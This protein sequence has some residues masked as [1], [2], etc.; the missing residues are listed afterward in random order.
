LRAAFGID[1]CDPLSYCT[2]MSQDVSSARGMG[3]AAVITVML[4]SGSCNTLLMKFMVIQYVPT[5]PNGE[6]TG[7][8]HPYFQSLLMMIGEMLCLIAYWTSRTPAEDQVASG[9]VPVHIFAVACLFDWTATTL[10]NM[11][12]GVIAASVVQMT[13][14]AIVIFTCAF[15]VAFLGK[16][17]HAYHLLGVVLVFM[18]ITM[19][20]LS[21]FINPRHISESPLPHDG[22][23]AVNGSGKVFG[24]ALCV[25]AQV[26]QALMLV[27]EESIMSKYTIPPLQVVGMEGLFGFIFGVVLLTILNAA[28]IESTP[29]AYYQMTHSKPLLLAIVASICSIAFF[30]FSGVTVTQRASAVARSTIDVSR[31]IIIWM[32][33]L[34]LGWNAFNPLQLAGFVVLALGTLIYNRIIVIHSLEPAPEASPIKDALAPNLELGKSKGS[35]ATV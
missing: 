24:I 20:S 11:A 29:A 15:T 34:A 32:V 7:F 12:Y 3:L 31:T 23:P 10:V 9:N 19:V 1:L 25:G 27:Y 18:G 17:Q 5:S 21:T 35:K 28:H 14:G 6:P 4:I 33:E 2:A 8:D 26:F 30:N 16:R 22:A 13:R